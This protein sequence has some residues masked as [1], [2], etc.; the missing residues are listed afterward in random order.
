MLVAGGGEGGEE[1]FDLLAA[2]GFHG[3][4]DDGVAEID[5]VVGA[6]VEGVDDVGA[7]RGDDR[8][9][10]GEGSGAI[11]EMDAEAD[12]A[13]VLDEAALDDA[14]EE[15]DV[16]VAAA[17]ED[18]DAGEGGQAGAALEHSGEGSG[19]GTFGEGL[20]ALKEGEDGAGDLVFF[21]GDDLVD[22]LAG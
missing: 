12:E 11:E 19:A 3:H 2:A 7:V 17:D 20:F 14:A 13:A 15:G 22:E 8:G 5:A 4:V 10:V 6:V 16:D 18:G 21:D 1:F 9:E